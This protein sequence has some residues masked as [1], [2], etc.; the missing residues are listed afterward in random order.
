MT[1]YRPLLAILAAISAMLVAC[2]LIYTTEFTGGVGGWLNIPRD[3]EN[4]AIRSE[5]QDKLLDMIYT[6]ENRE[7]NLKAFG[8]SD[9]MIRR[10]MADITNYERNHLQRMEES[11]IEEAPDMD[12]VYAAFCS[13]SNARRP[14]YEA[15]KFLVDEDNGRRPI[16]IDR[17]QPLNYFEWA[18]TAR[19]DAVYRM[20]ELPTDGNR[21]DDATL[22]GVAAILLAQEGVVIDGDAP[23]GRGVHKWS[24]E[25]VEAKYPYVDDRA[26]AYFALLHVFSELM[27]K[28]GALCDQ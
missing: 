24:W 18:D 9:S 4:A 17:A 5:V 19:I 16:N 23:W 22:M 25:D 3:T 2:T 27:H 13:R 6:K 21:R 8:L 28:E 1:S 7:D 26:V 14:R 10:T 11:L 15:L 12:Q 20:L